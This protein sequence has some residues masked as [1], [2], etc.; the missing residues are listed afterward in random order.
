MCK[1]KKLKNGKKRTPPDT[2]R[3]DRTRVV[4]EPLTQGLRRGNS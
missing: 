3:P 4:A 1:Q 2:G